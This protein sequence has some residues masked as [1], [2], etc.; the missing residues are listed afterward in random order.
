M[1]LMS[2]IRFLL[3]AAPPTRTALKPP[4]GAI[5]LLQESMGMGGATMGVQAV[6]DILGAG[7]SRHT[8]L[9]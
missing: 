2:L 7:S 8:Y 1:F 6:A 9:M 4:A 5:E 3:R